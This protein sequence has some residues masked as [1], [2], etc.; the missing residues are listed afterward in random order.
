MNQVR[1]RQLWAQMC[2]VTV[3]ATESGEAERVTGF[4]NVA[5]A[6]DLPLYMSPAANMGPAQAEAEKIAAWLELWAKAIRGEVSA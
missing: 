1:A 3:G 4:G 6:N 5:T 2:A